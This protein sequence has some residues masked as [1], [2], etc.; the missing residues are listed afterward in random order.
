MPAKGMSSAK[1]GADEPNHRPKKFRSRSSHSRN[2]TPRRRSLILIPSW[3]AGQ[4]MYN[5]PSAN[6]RSRTQTTNRLPGAGRMAG[7][8]LLLRG[9]LERL[10]KNGGSARSFPGSEKFRET[11]QNDFKNR[12]SSIG[13]P[14]VGLATSSAIFYLSCG[15]IRD[16]PRHALHHIFSCPNSE[17]TLYIYLFIHTPDLAKP[18]HFHY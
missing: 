5:W 11:C 12:Y 8:I 10:M 14:E 17:K 3:S 1:M 9:R 7:L 15:L 16:F 6:N 2:P 4:K 13:V 18:S